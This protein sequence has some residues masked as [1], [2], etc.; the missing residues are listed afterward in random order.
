MTNRILRSSYFSLFI[1]NINKSIFPSASDLGTTVL[2]LTKRL[3]RKRSVKQGNY[4]YVYI[5]VPIGILAV[6]RCAYN[7]IKIVALPWKM[8]I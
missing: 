3:R 1:N 6:C 4:T 5:Y 2:F 7:V 8:K